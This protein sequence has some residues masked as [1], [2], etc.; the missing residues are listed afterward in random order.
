MKAPISAVIIGAILLAG[1][2]GKTA[3]KTKAELEAQL[4]P[5]WV[6]FVKKCYSYD[7]PTKKSEIVRYDADHKPLR[8][9]QCKLPDGTIVPYG[10]KFP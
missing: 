6:A 4:S 7:T 8:V 3:P 5:Q 10:S 9:V 1:C 2:G